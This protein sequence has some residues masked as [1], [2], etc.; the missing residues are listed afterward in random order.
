MTD[1]PS[2]ASQLE[3]SPD[4]RVLR[5]LV[6]WPIMDLPPHMK[7]GLII[8]V[9]TTGL[10][11]ASDAIIEIGILQFAY[12]EDNSMCVIGSYSGFQDPGKPI[13]ADITK[14]TGITDD[15][16]AGRRFDDVR[17]AELID[18]ANLV[19]AHNAGFDRRFCE[20]LAPSLAKKPWACS[21]SQVD[22]KSH[23]FQGTKLGYLLAGFG[24]FHDGHRALDDC[25]ATLE[26]LSRPL[27]GINTTGF[28]QMIAAAR[29]PSY[30]VIAEGA[31]FSAKDV[32]KARGYFWSDGT[33]G[34]P[35]A[36]CKDF[37]KEEVPAEW[38][39]L[40]TEAYKTTKLPDCV[41]SKYISATDRFSVRAD[42]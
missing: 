1:F 32:L 26:I 30:R 15:M 21:M 13:P 33:G 31:P 39:W 4:Y 3:T 22:W 38:D 37:A 20:R 42:E 24:L 35:K 17:I 14:L 5:R 41:R 10:D 6:P 40:K 2:L 29:S 19:V 36:W 8:D 11:P 28:G 12:A 25:H 27:P 16:V 23:G 18:C 7:I 34:K 9:E